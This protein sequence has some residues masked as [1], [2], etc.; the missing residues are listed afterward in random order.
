MIVKSRQSRLEDAVE[1]RFSGHFSN[2]TFR[3]GPH[4]CIG[5]QYARITARCMVVSFVSRLEIALVDASSSTDVGLEIGSSPPV[6]F[7]KVLDGWQL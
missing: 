4:R 5:E 7:F 2:A 3:V 1:K 6:S